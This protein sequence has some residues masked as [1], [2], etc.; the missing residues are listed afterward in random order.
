MLCAGLVCN[1]ATMSASGTKR[2]HGTGARPHLWRQVRGDHEEVQCL[3]VVALD[4]EDVAQ[5]VVWVSCIGRQP[6]HLQQQLDSLIQTASDETVSQ[7]TINIMHTSWWD[8]PVSIEAKTTAESTTG[9]TLT[10]GGPGS[11]A[12]GFV[13]RGV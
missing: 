5:R 11:S 10:A 7:H 12:D 1:R 2:T 3:A 9:V 8:E 4:L 6:D 13:H